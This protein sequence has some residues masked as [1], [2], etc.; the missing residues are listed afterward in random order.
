MRL[1]FAL[2]LAGLLGCRSSDSSRD[3]RAQ[4]KQGASEVRSYLLRADSTSASPSVSA[5]PHLWVFAG[6]DTDPFCMSLDSNGTGLFHGGF[7]A[8]NPLR[9]RWDS[10]TRRLDISFSN[11]NA[12]DYVF[13]KAGVARRDFLAF[14]SATGTSSYLLHPTDPHLDIFNWILEPAE[15]IKDWQTPSA[16]KGCP[17]LRRG[18]GA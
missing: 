15:N 3:A 7:E 8:N 17:L 12:D 2:L 18:G 4:R 10:T 1:V 9:W 14:D 11:L 5:L 6:G 13:L 16:E